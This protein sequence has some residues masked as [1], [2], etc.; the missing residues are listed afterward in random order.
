MWWDTVAGYLVGAICGGVPLAAGRNRSNRVA[1]G[2][3]TIVGALAV[4]L[5]TA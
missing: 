3:F 2:A 5:T 1:F 4:W